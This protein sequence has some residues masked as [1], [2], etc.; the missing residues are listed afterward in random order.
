[1]KRT[2]CFHAVGLRGGAF[3]TPAVSNRRMRKTACPVVWEGH[4]AQ[5]PCLH[6][7]QCSAM[8]PE[9]ILPHSGRRLVGT[10]ALQIMLIMSKNETME[11]GQ[12]ARATPFCTAR[13]YGRGCPLPTLPLF[14]FIRNAHP[15]HLPITYTATAKVIL[16]YI[17]VRSAGGG[18]I[19]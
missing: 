14:I 11:R 15:C 5:S 6:P 18:L 17:P 19:N 16:I 4:G 1:M 10:L 9:T 8:K 12:D 2:R 13:C 3:V 7:V